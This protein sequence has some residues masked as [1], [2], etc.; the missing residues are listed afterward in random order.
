MSLDNELHD[1]F[2]GSR[3]PPGRARTGHGRFLRVGHVAARGRH[4]RRAGSVAVLGRRYWWLAG[5]PRPSDRRPGCD[6]V[7]V[8]DEGFQLT[9]PAA[10]RSTGTD[11]HC[12][13]PDPGGP[14]GVVGVVLASATGNRARR[15]SPSG[16]MTATSLGRSGVEGI[17]R[18]ADCR[19]YLRARTRPAGLGHY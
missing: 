4:G 19:R 6:T 12:L 7:Q 2:A 13:G 3:T 8:P 10:G 5:S 18:R 11:R 1:L 14:T 9:V 16:P 17:N 15:R